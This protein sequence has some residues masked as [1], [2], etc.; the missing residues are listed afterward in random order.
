MACQMAA[1]QGWTLTHIDLKTAFLQG[2]AYGNTR[3]VICQLPPEAGYPPYIGARLTK[4]AYGMN[5]APRRWWNI[6][7][8]AFLWYGMVPTR[9]DR[10]CYVLYSDTEPRARSVPDI[11]KKQASGS[12]MLNDNEA[13]E[14]AV[15]YLLDPV[16]GSPAHG[17]RVAGVI[18]IHVDDIFAC[19]NEELERRVLRPLRGDFQVGSED[20]DDVKFVGQK[21]AWKTERMQGVDVS[22][23]A[24]SQDK[25]IA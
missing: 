24:V 19:G 8:A 13:C 20:K 17:K 22:Y 5:D 21:I 2:E 3:D 16:T 14:S 9:A 23:I 10:C 4:P 11:P 6:I 7:D 15:E 1:I 18:S 25:E 12:P